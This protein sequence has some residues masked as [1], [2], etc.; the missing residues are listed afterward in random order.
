M[1][2][3]PGPLRRFLPAGAPG[4]AAVAGVP[5]DRVADA[6][7]ELEAVFARLAPT[8][9]LCDGIVEQGRHDADEL[10][11]RA[12]DEVRSIAATAEQRAAG[13]RADAMA[14]AQQVGR[15]VSDADLAAARARA[16]RLRAQAERR[17][18][19]YVAR[20]AAAVTELVDAAE[21]GPR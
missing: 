21:D 1:P 16:A 17:M 7:A 4:P 8:E 10:R 11:R 13:E 18:G 14:R 20:V 3:I 15:Q 6:I 12:A 19:D 2:R 9:A 5:Q